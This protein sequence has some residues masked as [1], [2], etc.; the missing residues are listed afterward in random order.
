MGSGHFLVSLI[1]Y[2]AGRIF[3]VMSHAAVEAAA[4][5]KD[6]YASPLIARL[7]S[8][9]ERI[10]AEAAAN[11][12]T[13]RAEQLTDQNLIKRM[14]LKRC[15][16]GVD[17]NLMAVE[18]AKVAL[19]LH[20]FTA[21]APLSF[22]D[23]HLRCG[24]SLFGEKVRRAVDELSQRGSLLISNE[25]RK[26]EAA[27][28]GMEQIEALTDAE[29]AEVR[30]SDET[31]ALVEESTR[32]LKRFLDFWQAIKWLDL[33]KDEEHA[34]QA[35]L[36]GQFGNPLE[37]AAGLK[38]PI[39]P[40]ELAPVSPSLFGERPPIQMTLQGTGV[41]SS[42]DYWALKRLIERAHALAEEVRFFHWEVA[43]PGVWRDWQSSEPKGGFDAVIGNPPWD[44]MKMQEVEW[45]A[46]RAPEVAKQARAAD[47]KEAIAKLRA[48]G[49]PL[50][51]HYDR[52]SAR[53]EKAMER[54]RRSG[55]YPL[56]SRGDINIYSLFVERAQMFLKPDGT[57]GMLVPS[58]IMSDKQSENFLKA[59]IP[60]GR[61]LFGIDFFNKRNDGS[62]FFPDV[63]Y[64][65]KFCVFVCA[66]KR[67]G[68]GIGRFAFFV[69]SMD[70]AARERLIA[71]DESMIQAISP[72]SFLV[73]VLR[74]ETD[75]LLASKMA[76]S[77]NSIRLRE[78]GVFHYCNLFHMA[79]D[80]GLFATIDDLNGR[81]AYPN[82][83]GSWRRGDD[84][85]AR[86]FEG[87]MVQAFDHRAASIGFYR[88][89]IFRTGESEN[90]TLDLYREPSFVAIPRFF[91]DAKDNRWES[92]YA[93]ALAIKDITS[94]TNTR[95][96]IAALI[97]RAGAGHT[98]PILFERGGSTT[99]DS[100]FAC[101]NLNA[102]VV[103][104]FARQKIHNNHLTL[105][106]IEQ[107][108]LIKPAAY[109]CPL[110][111]TVAEAIVRDHVL[112]LTYTACDM[113]P[114]ARDM[115]FN[116]EPFEW[117]EDER[118]HL[119]ARLDALYFHLYGL[120]D[121]TDIRYIL[122]TFPIVERKDRATH[123]GV[124]LTAELIIWYFRALAAG[125]PQS[126]AP[127]DLVIRNA[128]STSTS[129]AKVHA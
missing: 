14:V 121:E 78:L 99:I 124:Y 100:V 23:H 115:G 28:T 40:T 103:D 114:F 51:A 59:V 75:F 43:F 67:R 79:A 58:G 61:L 32:P 102:F 105:N 35:L 96:T 111:K 72:T 42:R 123:D 21:G 109:S 24:D 18:L 128:K 92:N 86:L 9:R 116:E 31:F 81:G 13:V 44:R 1:D 122:S 70:D 77:A 29:I 49:V 52:A 66:R 53:A 16:Y 45:F 5:A 112:R 15:V 20:T 30:Q 107:L 55:D 73:P 10:V 125:D 89:N 126:Q 54:A 87:K 41:A 85:F 90:T 106:I 2:L 37:V 82:A 6:G 127:V 93:W 46:A 117:D 104:F 94:T 38:P 50:A 110:G 101:A 22:L 76:E 118:R 98:L 39:A 11:G 64:R 3:T 119:R 47:R 62:L 71:I 27:I 34:L 120:T 84:A 69:R 113:E 12:W 65:Y 97:P 108:P 83:D 60:S 95:S 36:D 33:D 48:A 80:S 26:A 74:N 129:T 88:D 7:A 19:W 57:S 63:Y 91:V 8:I 25:I 68:D 4:W 17:K 56:L